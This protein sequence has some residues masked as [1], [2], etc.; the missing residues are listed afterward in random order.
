MT[1]VRI[2]MQRKG[3]RRMSQVFLHALEVLSCIQHTDRKGVAYIMKA[4]GFN[5]AF[6]QGSLVVLV[7]RPAHQMLS[8]AIREN[9]VPLVL[10][11]VAHLS[12]YN[13]PRKLDHA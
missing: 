11:G 12:P 2:L 10:P 3:S 1:D 8:D 5:S 7:Y 4:V 13:G 6:L 9:Q